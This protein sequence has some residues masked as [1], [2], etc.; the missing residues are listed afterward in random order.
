M[1]EAVAIAAGAVGALTVLGWLMDRA[2]LR[3][4]TRGWVYWRKSKGLKAVGVD[5]MLEGS[6]AAK[7]LERAMQDERTRKNVRPA[8]EPPFDVDLDAGTVRIRDE[9]RQGQAHGRRG[10]NDE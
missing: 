10:G 4:E 1:V 5:L 2:L 7:A 6:P 9:G 8:E 3:L